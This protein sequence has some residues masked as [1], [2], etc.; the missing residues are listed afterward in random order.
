[1]YRASAWVGCSCGRPGLKSHAEPGGQVGR[2]RRETHMYRGLTRSA[3]S[4]SDSLWPSTV[5]R[6]LRGRGGHGR[7][8]GGGEGAGPSMSTRA[9]QGRC[10]SACLPAQAWR[11][12]LRAQL[13]GRSGC[14]P[15]LTVSDGSTAGMPSSGHDSF[16]LGSCSAKE[17]TG[18][19]VAASCCA[20]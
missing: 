13:A 5:T 14:L 11:L 15:H 1:M 4:A 19:A 17:Q 10:L 18:S 16:H 8:G 2:A 9:P 12:A 20:L 3:S 7:V 6:Q